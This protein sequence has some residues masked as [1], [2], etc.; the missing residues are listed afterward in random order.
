MAQAAMMAALTKGKG[1]KK[2]KGKGKKRQGRHSKK[3]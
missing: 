1:K 2:H 3:K